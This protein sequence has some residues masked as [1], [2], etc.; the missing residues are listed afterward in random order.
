[1]SSSVRR[2]RVV[3]E[4]GVATRDALKGLA[5][6]FETGLFVDARER[7]RRARREATDATSEALR[8][9]QLCACYE[10]TRAQNLELVLPPVLRNFCARLLASRG[11]KADR[12][13]DTD[14]ARAARSVAKEMNAA[15]GR[16]GD[17]ELMACIERH[18][19]ALARDVHHGRLGVEVAGGDG[20]DGRDDAAD[21]NAT[22]ADCAAALVPTLTPTENVRCLLT[23]RILG[24][25]MR[26]AFDST[27]AYATGGGDLPGEV[28]EIAVA[29]C[30]TLAKEAERVETASPPSKSNGRETND[31]WSFFGPGVLASIWLPFVMGVKQQIRKDGACGGL[32]HKNQA[33]VAALREMRELVAETLPRALAESALLIRKVAVAAAVRLENRNAAA[34]AILRDTHSCASTSEDESEGGD[35]NTLNAVADDAKGETSEAPAPASTLVEKSGGLKDTAFVFAIT[36]AEAIAAVRSC[37]TPNECRATLAEPPVRLALSPVALTTRV[38]GGDARN[39]NETV[40]PVGAGTVKG[41]QVVKD[42]LREGDGLTLRV[43]LDLNE[44]NEPRSV[45]HQPIANARGIRDSAV[46]ELGPG[47]GGLDDEQNDDDATR[48]RTTQIATGPFQAHFV[49]ACGFL[50]DALCDA[51]TCFVPAKHGRKNQAPQTY[52]RASKNRWFAAESTASTSAKC[53]SKEQ[54]NARCASAAARVMLAGCRTV[55]GGDAL[56][57]VHALFPSERFTARCVDPRAARRV[58]RFAGPSVCVELR[59]TGPS[60]SPHT[61]GRDCPYETLTTFFFSSQATQRVWWRGTCSWCPQ[62]CPIVPHRLAPRYPVYWATYG[63]TVTLNRCNGPPSRRLRTRR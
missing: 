20:H 41:D 35:R 55:R 53:D 45:N 58:L 56:D 52:T 43:G 61:A 5:L 33:S 62:L 9:Y 12:S 28:V 3:A 48:W 47:F 63:Q 32:G 15:P 59:G 8:T 4:G 54:V 42:W 57:F 25:A 1:M 14:V 18:L 44:W 7:D 10:L 17:I 31:S 29:V 46:H 49:S 40:R 38:A 30:E 51:G 6:Q 36:R 16:D 39:E 22:A 37:A 23:P 21:A 2:T 27:H 11:R 19:L 34:E 13:A 60:Q 24:F 50:A 26:V